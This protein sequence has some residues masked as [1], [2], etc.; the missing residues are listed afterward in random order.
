MPSQDIAILVLS[1]LLLIQQVYWSVQVHKLV[2]KLMSRNY[3]EYK[4]AEGQTL[5]MVAPSIILPE[6]EDDLG[7]LGD[8][9]PL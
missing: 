6:S 5:P 2:D 3:H 8:Y 1:A 7:S 4:Q 9:K